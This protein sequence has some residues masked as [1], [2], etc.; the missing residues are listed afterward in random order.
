M[1]EKE[2]KLINE[3]I[4]LLKSRN[5]KFLNES[6]C[7]KNLYT[8]GYYEIVN[9]YKFFLLD[10][11][12]TKERNEDWYK[13]D[14]YFEQIFARFILDKKI[15]NSI[16]D[17]TLEI[18]CSLRSAIA[19]VIA[20]NFGHKENDYLIKTHYNKGKATKDDYG[21]VKFYKI[22]QIFEKFTN[23]LNDDVQPIKH[24]RDIHGNVPPWILLKGATF[25]NLVNFLKLQKADL[26]NEILSI[27][28]GREKNDFNNNDQLKSFYIDMIFLIHKFR[29]RAAHTGRMYNYSPKES[30]VSYFREFH[31]EMGIS[32]N[33]YSTGTRGKSDLATLYYG[34]EKFANFNAHFQL[35]FSLNWNISAHLKE[36]PDD[37]KM[38]LSG[39]GFDENFR[40]K[41]YSKN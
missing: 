33:A 29:N 30:E 26:K 16:L 11:T 25:G 2:F 21:N 10:E 8:Y 32:R 34:I 3:Q 36:F 27:M 17:A 20:R 28:S 5:L 19:Y 14:S 9:G 41:D 7:E 38:L 15:R 24:Y 31:E 1:I 6:I 22:D 39:M 4:E 35:D 13:E 40:I 37:E 18:E 12:I 23:I